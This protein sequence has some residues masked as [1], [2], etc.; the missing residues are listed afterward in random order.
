MFQ[1]FSSR[2]NLTNPVIPGQGSC[3]ALIK[4]MENNSDIYASHVAWYYLESM[5][6]MQKKYNFGYHYTQNAKNRKL[7]PGHSVAFSGYPGI[8]YSADDFH[9]LSSGLATI[10]TSIENANPELWKLIKPTGGILEGVRVTVANRLAKNGKQWTHF[11][12]MKNSGTYNNCSVIT[13]AAKWN[14]RLRDTHI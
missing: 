13:Y 1:M 7:V 8:I 10:E 3:S 12:S 5:L 11:F 4:V 9:L 6:R 2:Y 14:A